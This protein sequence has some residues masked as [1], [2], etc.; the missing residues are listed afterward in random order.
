MTASPEDKE[1]IQKDIDNPSVLLHNLTAEIHKEK[2]SINKNID[3]PFVFTYS[4]LIFYIDVQ[5]IE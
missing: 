2:A 1:N 5:Y 3:N 4:E